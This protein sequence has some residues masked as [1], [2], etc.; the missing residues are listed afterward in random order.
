MIII[1]GILPRS[2]CQVSSSVATRETHMWVSY[3][4]F[5]TTLLNPDLL[6]IELLA[7]HALLNGKTLQYKEVKIEGV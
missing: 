4:D 2:T 3:N 7:D 5:A 1:R 6:D